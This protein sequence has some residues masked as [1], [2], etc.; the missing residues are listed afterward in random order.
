MPYHAA[1][2]TAV[3]VARAM[4][5]CLQTAVRN[6]SAD[7]R[8]VSF[9]ATPGHQLPRRLQ[10]AS[11]ARPA[12]EICRCSSIASRERVSEKRR[13][14]AVLVVTD[15]EVAVASVSDTD[16]SAFRGRTRTGANARLSATRRVHDGQSCG[17]G[18]EI[19]QV[20]HHG[21][22]PIEG[23]PITVTRSAHS[24][25]AKLD[26]KPGWPP[27]AEHVEGDLDLEP[28]HRHGHAAWRGGAACP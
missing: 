1:S 12:A 3:P 27:P 22:L 17:D 16:N 18:Q 26:R 15:N 23:K 28:G 14:P 5:E 9:P 20:A 4:A 6:E 7:V 10:A 24:R 11:E 8:P 19:A 21:S 2:S 13:T 25:R